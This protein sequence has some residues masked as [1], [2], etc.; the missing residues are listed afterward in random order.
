MRAEGFV[1]GLMDGRG[2]SCVPFGRCECRSMPQLGMPSGYRQKRPHTRTRAPT[3]SLVSRRFA[4]RPF[5]NSSAIAS[6]KTAIERG[7]GPRSSNGP[8]SAIHLGSDPGGSCG[9][10][11]PGQMSFGRFIRPSDPQEERAQV[12]F[13][14]DPTAQRP[15]APWTL[16]CYPDNIDRAVVLPMPL[17]AETVSSRRFCWMPIY[18]QPPR[19]SDEMKTWNVPIFSSHI[20]R[21]L[22]TR[23]MRQR[24]QFNQFINRPPFQTTLRRRQS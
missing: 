9:V 17:S 3:R 8:C 10:T 20:S 4:M 7:L 22:H 15:S 14:C 11:A 12:Q 18:Q 1:G 16:R 5:G 23:E 2:P 24:P 21:V 13:I 19:R 6:G